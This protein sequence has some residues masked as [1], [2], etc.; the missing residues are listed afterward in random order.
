MKCSLSIKAATLKLVDS[1][2]LDTLENIQNCPSQTHLE[3]TPSPELWF[4]EKPLAVK[5]KTLV[6]SQHSPPLSPS[7][8]IPSSKSLTLKQ[9]KDLRREGGMTAGRSVFPLEWI[10]RA[11]EGRNA[12]L[13]AAGG[14]DHWAYWS[15]EN[16]Y[17][18]SKS[19]NLRNSKEQWRTVSNF[20]HLEK[21]L[22]D[23][24][25]SEFL[26]QVD[27]MNS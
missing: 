15:P 17:R 4:K 6:S 11:A 22:G 19:G 12:M 8:F 24:R 1:R 23:L 18:N 20:T 3:L 5:V 10:K 13:W 14:Q 7:P 21:G 9:K 25:I 27:A 26:A 16:S 2:Y